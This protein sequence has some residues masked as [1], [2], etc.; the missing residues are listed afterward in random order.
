M[1][2]DDD[3]DDDDDERRCIRS[4]LIMTLYVKCS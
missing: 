2:D 4:A 1:D 3:D